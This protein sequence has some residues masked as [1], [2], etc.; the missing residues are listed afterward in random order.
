MQHNAGSP[1]MNP[2]KTAD[3]P[4]PI[5]FRNHRPGDMGYITHRHGV[6]YAKE[7]NYGELFE[8]MVSQITADFL[9]NYD[10]AKERCWIAERDDKFLG[11]IM[12]IRDRET[13]G[14]A[15]LRCFFVEKE[16]RGSGLGTELIR[17][18][19]AFAREVGYERIGLATDFHLAS[20]RRLYGKAGFE[21]K[22][23]EEHEA[24]GK[25]RMG[26]TWELQLK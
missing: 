5:T 18:C 13:I 2:I 3:A 9:L 1:K 11:A 23:T 7:H 21:L 15:K 26:E 19:V 16:A 17:L 6:I 12:L 20:A 8:A 24:W 4:N 14:R 22:A 25:K 10:P